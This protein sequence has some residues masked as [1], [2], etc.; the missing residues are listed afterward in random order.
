MKKQSS[1]K[2]SKVENK[3]EE[4]PEE[5]KKEEPP[6]ETSG[7]GEFVYSEGITYIGDWKLVD[8]VK[9]KDGHGKLTHVFK[10]IQM[11]V[12]EEYEGE[13]KNDMMDGKGVYKYASGATYSGEWKNNRHHGKG[14]YKT[15]NGCKYEGEWCEHKFHGPGCYTD[16]DNIDWKGEYV[17]GCYE[18]KEQKR[19]QAEREMI[20]YVEEAKKSIHDTFALFVD[21]FTQS[22]KKTYKENLSPFFGNA[23]SIGEFFSEPYIKPEERPY[24]K[25]NNIIT[26]LKDAP[27]LHFNVLKA[28]ANAT[29]I[30][31][32]RV[33]GKQ[34][35][36]EGGQIVEVE[37]KV[38]EEQF[39]KIVMCQTKEKKWAICFYQDNMAP[40]KKK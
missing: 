10:S 2:G 19:L 7:T 28:A 39:I 27:E 36:K 33:K 32:E 4:V 5:E 18:S 11:P 29:M 20:I 13:W 26:M 16:M 6:V 3:K 38:E 23:E 14:V 37:M 1:K 34:L 12:V 35:L 17:D 8:G 15:A 31:P 25:W 9:V 22:D 24:D 30:D 21:T 40:A